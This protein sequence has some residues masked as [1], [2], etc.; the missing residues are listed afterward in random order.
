MVKI[1]NHIQT[2]YKISKNLTYNHSQ[3][4]ILSYNKQF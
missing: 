4:E 3:I 2:V 1:S